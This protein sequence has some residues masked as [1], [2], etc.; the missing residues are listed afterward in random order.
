MRAAIAIIAVLF[1][2]SSFAD[3]TVGVGNEERATRVSSPPQ[4][5]A[6][7]HDD[8]PPDSSGSTPIPHGCFPGEKDYAWTVTLESGSRCLPLPLSS[9]LLLRWL[10]KNDTA[11]CFAN[12]PKCG[13]LHV[14]IATRTA[15]V[16]VCATV[17]Q[18]TLASR[19][20]MELSA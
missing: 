10:S 18:A 13:G 3:D 9:V 19:T 11:T 6:N 16:N 4:P 20:A 7:T 17:A 5:K 8:P 1:L 2:G 14:C 15:S 12:K